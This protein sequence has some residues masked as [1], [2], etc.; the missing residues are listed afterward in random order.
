MSEEFDQVPRTHSG[1]L[2]GAIAAALLLAIGGLI[3][4]YTL[5][6]KLTAQQTELAAAQ[7]ANTNVKAELRETDARLE[8]ATDELKTSLGVTQKQLDTR[9]AELQERQQR[10]E[11][12]AQQLASAQ[13]QTAQQVTAV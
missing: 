12:N 6:T 13:K 2:L 3:W 10:T 9:A 11:A 7:Q 1:A 8:V 4:S 5:N